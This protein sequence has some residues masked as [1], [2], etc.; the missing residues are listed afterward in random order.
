MHFSLDELFEQVE[1]HR[2]TF[3]HGAL[4]LIGVIREELDRMEEKLVARLRD[5][6]ELSWEEIGRL[7][8]RSKQAVWEKHRR[9]PS[10]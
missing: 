10:A 8:G 3:P 7:V 1:Q 6:E 5:D 9:T 2:E 4:V